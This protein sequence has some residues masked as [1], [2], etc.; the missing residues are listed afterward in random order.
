MV[1]RKTMSLVL[2]A[3]LAAGIIAGCSGKK[4]DGGNQ[5]P[6]PEQK[7][8]KVLR[9]NMGADPRYM[10]PVLMTD[11]VAFTAENQ[12]FEGLVRITAKGTVAGMAAKWDVLDN[13]AKYR[14]YLRDGLKW[15]NGD[16]ITAEDFEFAW[17]RALDPKTAAEYA[18]QLYYIKGG[19]ALNSVKLKIKGADGKE[20]DNPDAEKQI[21]EAQKNLGVKVV[22]PKT[23]EVTLEAPTPYFL[24]LTAFPTLHPVNKKVVSANKDWAAKAE[25][26]ISNGPFK[27]QTWEPKKQMVMVKNPNYW[28]AAN[29][30]L[31]KL[32]YYMVEEQA[33]ALNMYETDQVDIIENPPSPEI[34]RLQKEGKLKIAPSYGTYYYWFNTQKKPF[35]NVKVR[36]A[37]TLAI[38]RKAIVDNVS[39]GGEIPAYAFVA[40]G[41]TD[42]VANKDF[43]EA[44][45][46][47]LKEDVAAAKK[48]LADAGYPEGKG[49]PEVS[50]IYNTNERHKAIAEAIIEMWKKNLGITSVKMQNTE[51]KIVLD[52]RHKGDFEIARA[53]WYGDYLDAMTFMDLMVTDGGNNDPK[54]SNKEYDKLID[55]A[56]KSGDQK[57]RMEA[58][59]KAEKIV[60]DEAPFLPIFYYT[61]PYLQKESITNTFHNALGIWDFKEADV[62]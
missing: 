17:R 48:L 47:L 28:D 46:N 60:V 5:A 54:W 32:V 8:E 27:M 61:F 3:S 31:E 14:F 7:K 56:K 18:Y 41:S 6:K 9:Y 62:K 40:P 38:D 24:D 2:A 23:L 25:S 52:K 19:E 15:S 1:F 42:P 12:M 20:A 26:Y 57:V 55:Q 34:P 58:M 53:G 43:R 11:L 4:S 30:K 16:P 37:L 51:W 29:V 59:H 22:D 39:K 45:G 10:D 44:G 50:F 33:T 36:Q 21:A 35:D 13:G 49:F